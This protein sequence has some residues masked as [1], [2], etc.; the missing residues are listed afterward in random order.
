[1]FIRA[2]LIISNCESKT[3]ALVIP[4]A[5]HGIPVAHKKR[6]GIETG[7][8]VTRKNTNTPATYTTIILLLLEIAIAISGGWGNLVCHCHHFFKINFPCPFLDKENINK[9]PN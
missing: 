2:A 3:N 6:H 1:M 5:G 9:P 4:Q 8:L 7:V